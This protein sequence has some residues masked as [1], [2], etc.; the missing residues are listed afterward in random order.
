MK[1]FM[2]F[3]SS[4]SILKGLDLVLEY[5]IENPQYN[6]H[7]VGPLDEEF[8]RFYQKQI[9]KCLNITFYNFLDTSSKEFMNLAY[10]CAFN[11]FPSGSEGCPGSV[12]TLMQMGVIPITS[13]WGAIDQIEH[14]G[15]LLPELSVEA[16]SKAIEWGVTLPREEFHKIIEENISYSKN[17]WNLK[18]FENEFRSL[19]LTFIKKSNPKI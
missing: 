17:T 11:I 6:L 3:G 5:F 10:L 15:Y 8:I 19:L 13:Q 9:E 12:I 18:R 1:D 4:G 16:I 7:V 14:Y 2:W